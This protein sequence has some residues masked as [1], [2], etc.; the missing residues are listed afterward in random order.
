MTYD[1][2]VDEDVKRVRKEI[3]ENANSEV[4]DFEELPS[5]QDEPLVI[6]Y[7]PEE[8]VEA[9]PVQ[10]QPEEV[11]QEKDPEHFEQM[12]LDSTGTDGPGF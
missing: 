8:E 12:T 11:K 10:E 3:N 6:D 7:H 5:K 2:T 9:E 4:L 1:E